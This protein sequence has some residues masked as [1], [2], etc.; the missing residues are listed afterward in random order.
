M[1]KKSEE[2]SQL[3]KKYHIARTNGNGEMY[4]NQL[5]EQYLPLVKT[6]AKKIYQRSSPNIELDDLK[7]EGVFGLIKAI[8]NFESE[9]NVKFEIY[10]EFRIN[11]SI[12]DYLRKV[13]WWPR[14]VKLRSNQLE[15]AKSKL[16]T[17]LDYEPTKGQLIKELSK[18]SYF[19]NPSNNTNSET[20]KGKEKAKKIINE[21]ETAQK[22]FSLSQ[23]R[24]GN[25][26][27]REGDFLENEK[28]LNPLYEAQEKDF[29][30]F[31]G[32]GLTREERLILDLYYSNYVRNKGKWNGIPMREIG[33]IIDISESA[34]SMKHT[35]LLLKIK[36]KLTVRELNLEDCLNNL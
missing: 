11:G 27:V 33:K 16:R 23:I 2:L 10:A 34:V 20:F 19:A 13:N 36:Y 21:V 18:D 32:K 9:K 3:W 15:R 30:D 25:E 31:L 17:K 22:I 12:L 5:I 14:L 1:T 24:D 4:K 28:A 35:A 29:K 7:S 8:E 26:N 6:V